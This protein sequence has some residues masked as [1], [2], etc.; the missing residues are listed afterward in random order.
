MVMEGRRA[1]QGASLRASSLTRFI[2]YCHV[3]PLVCL[4]VCSR[5]PFL[6]R[7]K[8]DGGGHVGQP[9]LHTNAIAAECDACLLHRPG[10]LTGWTH[11]SAASSAALSDL[12]F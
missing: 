1:G 5:A 6:G 8:E 10:F 4:H 7:T 11:S 9:K 2:S 3:A 12:F